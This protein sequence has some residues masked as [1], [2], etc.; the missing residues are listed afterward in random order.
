MSTGKV[1]WFNDSKGFGFICPR[2]L[3]IRSVPLRPDG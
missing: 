3:T 1:K 2:C